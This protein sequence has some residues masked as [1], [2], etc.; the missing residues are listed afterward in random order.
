MIWLF[1]VVLLAFC[2]IIAS[3][4]EIVIAFGAL[5]L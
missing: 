4:A 1:F 5:Y 2:R 3:P